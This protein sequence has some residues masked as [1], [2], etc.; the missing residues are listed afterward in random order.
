MHREMII[1]NKIFYGTRPAASDT[2]PFHKWQLHTVLFTSL[3]KRIKNTVPEIKRFRQLTRFIT[4]LAAQ[5]VFLCFN[6]FSLMAADRIVKVGVYENA[7]KVFTDESGKPS[8]IFIDI[9]ENIAKNEGWHL[10]Y[11]RGTWGEGL[12]RLIKGKIDLMPD[13]AYTADRG[14]L[15]DFHKIPVL[16]SWYQ[17]YA[18]KGSNIR[19][20]LD[21]KGKRILVLERSVQ[22]TAFARLSRGFGLNSIIIS[23]PDYDTMFE[24]IARGEA[25]AAITNRFYGLMHA[26]K[27]GLEDTAVIFEPS[28]LFFAAAKGKSKLLLDAIDIRLENLKNNPQSIFYKSLKKWTSE[29]VKF[30]FSIWLKIAALVT[31][32]ILLVAL[33]GNIL[34]KRQV[35]IRTHEFHEALRRFEDIVEFLPDA[36][37]VI[38]QDKKIIA[39]NKACEKL[40][41]V[42]KENLIGKSDYAYSEPFFGGRRPV[43]IDLLDKPVSETEALYKYVKREEDKLYAESFIQGRNGGIGQHLWGVA[44]PLY[45]RNGLRSGAIE[46]I[47]NITEQKHIEEALRASE[48][49]YRELVML[50]NTIILHWSHDGRILYM[51][52]F[53]LHFFGYTE[54]ELLGQHVVG[55]IVPESDSTG[56]DLRPLMESICSEPEKF[57]RNINENIKKSGEHVWI[58]WA[59]RVLFD[60]HGQVKEILS[61][62]SD[63]TENK[64]AEEKIR[65]LND[66]LQRHAVVLEQKV[67]ERTSELASAMEKAQDADKIKS[68]FLATMSHELRT[69]LNSIIGFTGILLQRLAGPLNDEQAKQLSMIQNSSRHLLS[70][71]NDV[72]DISKIEAGQLELLPKSFSLRNSI[73]KSVKL[74]MPLAE[75]KNIGINQEIADNVGEITADQRRIEQIILNLLNNAVKF[76][77]KGMIIISCGIENRLCRLSVSDTGIGM[78]Q[79]DI[80]SLFQPFHQIDSG[81]SRKVEGTGLGLSICKK[82]LDLMGGSISVRSKIGEGSTFT[83]Q[84]PVALEDTL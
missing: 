71:I 38:D 76:T 50:A 22:E 3:F 12:D 58:D 48:R 37:F 62:G 59:N 47:R 28:D 23:L 43:L 63:I 30:K 45:D 2:I 14:R 36:T 10:T 5:L 52:E 13:V 8:G 79:E 40:T 19:S 33:L 68:A 82:I 29:E 21:L 34:L 74:I 56:I 18:P 57:K 24:M 17:V 41:G 78:R 9:I 55:T 69:P 67:E 54:A 49:K 11:I 70:L 84:F 16:S 42:K 20:I 4:L 32:I 53:G 60:E 66:E 73:E 51:N 1:F 65:Q 77:E 46:C 61:I 39:W 27:S 25:D 7:P 64:K 35:N 6:I 44:A 81:T 26:K 31:G 83:I 72:L 75:K 15:Y 80:S